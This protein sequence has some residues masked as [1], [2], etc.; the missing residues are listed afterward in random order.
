MT[1]PYKDTVYSYD[2]VKLTEESDLG[3]AKL[4]FNYSVIHNL[5][6]EKDPGFEKHIGD[7]LRSILASPGSSIGKKALHDRKS[8]EAHSSQFHS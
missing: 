7:V 8:T 1:G 5:K 6:F 3:V 2:W 4:S